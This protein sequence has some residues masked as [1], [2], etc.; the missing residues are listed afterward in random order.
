M[1]F[2]PLFPP[3][4]S[5][6]VHARLDWRVL[7]ESHIKRLHLEKNPLMSKSRAHLPTTSPV[8]S[9]RELAGRR[10][11]A[12]VTQPILNAQRESNRNAR[13]A[14]GQDS[15]S[16]QAQTHEASRGVEAAV[17]ALASS[18]SSLLPQAQVTVGRGRAGFREAF[19]RGV[20][21]LPLVDRACK[22]WL[23]T[24]DV[25]AVCGG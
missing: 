24:A 5:H 11:L 14:A 3:A 15:A 12:A 8:H 21:A 18:S 19:V 7:H 2:I 22:D 17:P 6:S 9:L 4:S 13:E 10:A 25:C 16:T 23:L 1:P 20:E